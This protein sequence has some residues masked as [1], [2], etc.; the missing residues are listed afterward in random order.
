[1]TNQPDNLSKVRKSFDSY[2]PGKWFHV[3]SVDEMQEFYNFRLPFIREA[4][5][6]LGYA[7]GVHGSER[8]D[9]DLMAM[10]WRDDAAP[11]DELAKAVQMAA[12]GFEMQEVKWTDKPCGRKSISIHACWCEWYDMVSAGHIDLSVAPLT[13]LEQEIAAL[14]EE[15]N[16]AKGAV[17]ILTQVHLKDPDSFECWGIINRADIQWT[18]IPQDVYTNAWN[19]LRELIYPDATIAASRES[20]E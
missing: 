10:P 6:K 2:A 16:R 13:A 11:I 5:E 14:R 7:I 4:A 20:G 9:F 17:D 18:Y 15:N 1:M 8:R 3:Y 19:T 12:C